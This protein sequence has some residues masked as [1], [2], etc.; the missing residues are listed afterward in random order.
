MMRAQLFESRI[1]QK[2]KSVVVSLGRCRHG[3]AHVSAWLCLAPDS[4]NEM[5]GGTAGVRGAKELQDHRLTGMVVSTGAWSTG[6]TART[7]LEALQKLF[8]RPSEKC[9]QEDE[10]R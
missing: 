9:E 10:W 2:R 5:L 3:T 4:V 7:D 1:V 8:A 6:T